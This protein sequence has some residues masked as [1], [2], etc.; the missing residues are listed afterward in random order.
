MGLTKN[1]F[2]APVI[3][4]ITF[5][6]NV[7]TK[8]GIETVDY[9]VVLRVNR[10]SVGQRNGIEVAASLLNDSDNLERFCKLLASDPE[11]ID[12]FPKAP[13]DDRPLEIRAREYFAGP[14]YTE[15]IN[16]VV[17]EVERAQKPVEFFR[18]F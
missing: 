10:E 3:L 17:L 1:F 13:E 5:R 11:G 18:G 16:Y 6:A 14:V 9:P 2:T 4:P 7:E 15:L 8:N 12:D